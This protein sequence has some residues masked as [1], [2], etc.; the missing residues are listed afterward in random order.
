MQTLTLIAPGLSM[1]LGGLALGVGC[2]SAYERGF[3]AAPTV[4]AVGTSV[5]CWVIQAQ[6]WI[7]IGRAMP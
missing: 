1:A 4:A 2:A 3:G 7:E 6:L 5:L